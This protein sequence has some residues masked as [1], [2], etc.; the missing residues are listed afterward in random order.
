[1]QQI[2]MELPSSVET[3]RFSGRSLFLKR[4]DAIADD[5]SGNKARKFHYFLVH[6]FPDIR[7]VISYG[8]SQSNAMYSLSV[9]AQMRGWVFTYYVDH[10]SDY[11]RE[12]PHGNY[13]AALQNGMRIIEGAKPP[14]MLPEETLLIEEGGRQTEA[15][16]GV[17]ILA[18]EI[19]DWQREQGMEALSVF[20]PSGTGTTALFLAKVFGKRAGIG[21]SRPTVYTTPC[22]GDADY[23][24]KQFAM[25]EADE[26]YWPTILE[27]PRKYHF[28]K[29]YKENYEIWI[30]LQQQ[31]GIEFDLLYDPIGWQTLLAHPAVFDAPV[32]YIH[33]GGIKG[34]ESMIRRYERKYHDKNI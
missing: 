11:L 26:R 22:V 25:L 17:R 9:L 16:Y 27:P 31:T 12:N 3:L 33:Q 15:E 20:L 23:L 2:I 13:A 21:G 8:S 5:F 30:E 1:M 18:E 34:N 24:R 6:D 32:M 14:S 4:D 7:E 10:L 19:L 28:G 29:L